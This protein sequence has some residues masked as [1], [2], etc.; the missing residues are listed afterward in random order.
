MAT[1]TNFH[2][3]FSGGADGSQPNAAR[4]DLGAGAGQPLAC[5]R[6]NNPDRRYIA[7]HGSGGTIRMHLPPAILQ[8]VLAVLRNDSP[9]QIYFIQDGGFL[10]TATLELVDGRGR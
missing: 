6:F 7:D 3:V 9:V 1:V 2:I 10:G 4:L 5:V 8:N